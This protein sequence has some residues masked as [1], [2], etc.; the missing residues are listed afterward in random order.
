MT[1]E[2]VTVITPPDTFTW[3]ELLQPVAELVPVTSKAVWSKAYAHLIQE[4]S[5]R[6]GIN[7]D[8]LHDRIYIPDLKFYNEC[9]LAHNLSLTDVLLQIVSGIAM[10][11]LQQHVIYYQNN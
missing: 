2:F 9:R 11:T 4:R 8:V 7:W 5:L 10:H 6:Y 3:Q 1:K